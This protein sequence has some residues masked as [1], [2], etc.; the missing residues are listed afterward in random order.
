MMAFRFVW[1]VAFFGLFVRQWG[2]C[3]P[4]GRLRVRWGENRFRASS[5]D[6]LVVEE[7]GS[8]AWFA[9]YGTINGSGN[10]Y[11]MVELGDDSIWITVFDEY[12]TGGL[13]DLIR[14]RIRIRT[15]SP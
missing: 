7:D 9:G 11:F 4:Y 8:E 15:Y 14:G 3:G 13:V 1:S 12:D 5:V 6:W 10:H 2:E